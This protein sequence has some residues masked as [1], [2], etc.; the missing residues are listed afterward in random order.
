MVNRTAV[1]QAWVIQNQMKTLC[2]AKAIE[3]GTWQSRV[4]HNNTSNDHINAP[5]KSTLSKEFDGELAKVLSA[6]NR[7]K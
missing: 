1:H 3:I 7:N 2:H 4:K 6:R 5:K